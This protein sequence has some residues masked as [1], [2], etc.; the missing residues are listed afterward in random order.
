MRPLALDLFCGQ[1]GASMGLHRAGFDVVGVDF[2]RQ[3]HYPFPFVQADALNP[4]FNLSRFDFIWASPPCQAH[5]SLRGMWNSRI[6]KDCISETRAILIAS[7]VPYCMENVPGAPL[8]SVIKLCGTMFDLQTKCGAELRRHRYFETSFL[9]FEPEC[10]H[11]F[12]VLGVYG[13]H[14]RDRCR[15]VGVYGEGCRDASSDA[16][17]DPDDIG[18]TGHGPHNWKRDGRRVITVTGSTP[19]QNV[20]RNRI[21]RTYTADDARDAMGAPWMTIA[22]LSQAIPPAYG[23]FIGRAA[24]AFIRPIANPRGPGTT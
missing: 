10:R 20:E 9:M 4:P 24:M 1:G 5:T 8:R 6:H 13:G 12:S 23:E 18:V 11:G 7:G 14:V 3:R 16:R 19:Q 22:G 2:K 21:R 15:T 17:R